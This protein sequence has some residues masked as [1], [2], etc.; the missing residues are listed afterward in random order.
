MQY[1]AAA[2][3][4]LFGLIAFGAFCVLVWEFAGWLW[5]LNPAL[6]V[7]VGACP[8]S[9]AFGLL[10]D[11]AADGLEFLDNGGTLP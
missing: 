11:M 5:E 7:L 6:F 9:V 4:L 2:L 10:E 1:V 3:S 8:V